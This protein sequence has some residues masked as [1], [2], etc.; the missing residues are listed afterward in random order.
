MARHGTLSIKE[1]QSIF[2]QAMK[3]GKGV[4]KRCRMV[5][6]SLRSAILLSEI[7]SYEGRQ[8][9]RAGE[10][11]LGPEQL[12]VRVQRIDHQRDL[13]IHLIAPEES[14]GKKEEPRRSLKAVVENRKTEGARRTI[15]GRMLANLSLEN[16][17]W[18]GGARLVWVTKTD[19][20][21]HGREG[22]IDNNK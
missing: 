13:P 21:R 15:K 17:Y 8:G 6:D 11:G 9:C 18:M 5:K 2:R 10:G 22:I 16:S 3:E 7:V 4:K 20:S 1:S 12:A 19:R 14:I